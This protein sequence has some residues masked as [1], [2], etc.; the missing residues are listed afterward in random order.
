MGDISIS[1]IEFTVFFLPSDM[2]ITH[3]MRTANQRMMNLPN[4]RG[5]MVV[6][7]RYAPVASLLFE[8]TSF[9]I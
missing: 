8:Q 6:A 7:P 4:H 3:T 1:Q 5:R 9:L 2:T